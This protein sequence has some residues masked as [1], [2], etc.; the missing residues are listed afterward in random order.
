[1]SRVG[2]SGISFDESRMIQ[3]LRNYFGASCIVRT[4]SNVLTADQI[5]DLGEDDIWDDFFMPI[6]GFYIWRVER[7]WRK[8]IKRP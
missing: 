2:R 4:N 8:R 1:M 7:N 5:Q 6:L 3:E